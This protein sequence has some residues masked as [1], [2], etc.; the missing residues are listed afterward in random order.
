MSGNESQ[1]P[2]KEQ[3]LS[4]EMCCWEGW[5]EWTANAEL[6][7]TRREADEELGLAQEDGVIESKV[8]LDSQERRAECV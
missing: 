6:I 1:K 5:K 8:G 3:L 4:L 2:K 7:Q